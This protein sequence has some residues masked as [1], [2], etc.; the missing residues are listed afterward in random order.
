MSVLF[1]YDSVRLFA[2]EHGEF[3]RWSFFFLLLAIVVIVAGAVILYHKLRKA[4]FRKASIALLG[5]GVCVAV[6][7][8]S[9][10]Y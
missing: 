10:G 8:L 4:G 1:D 5:I 2:V 9:I 7:K 3:L 6:I